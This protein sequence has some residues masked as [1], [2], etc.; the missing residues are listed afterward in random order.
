MVLLAEPR[1]ARLICVTLCVS[2]A[3]CSAL[4][5]DAG[6]LSVAVC[7][8]GAL[9][10]RTCVRAAEVRVAELAGVACGVLG[11][12]GG[13]E[14]IDACG[15]CGTVRAELALG[16][17]GGG[18]DAETVDAGLGAGAGVIG[19]AGEDARARVT[20]AAEATLKVG[21]AAG[22][23]DV[24]GAGAV[25]ADLAGLAFGVGAALCG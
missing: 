1:D 14:A 2:A 23:G 24:C 20:H 18:V 16:P 10:D 21:L 13:T 6:H 25:D 7:A 22:V 11:A 12:L 17:A 3:E 9:G 15:G 4:R 19:L 8:D 5:V